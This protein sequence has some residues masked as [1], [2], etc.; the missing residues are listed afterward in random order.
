MSFKNTF[1]GIDFQVGNRAQQGQMDRFSQAV[2]QGI[3]QYNK[4]QDREL[5]REALGQKQRAAEAAAAQDY[6][7]V[8]MNELN[9]IAMGGAPTPDGQAAVKVMQQTAQDRMYT[10]IAGNVRTN[11][12]PWKN[13]G[14]GEDQST[15]IGGDTGQAPST[16]LQGINVPPVTQTQLQQGAPQGSATPFPQ[17]PSPE[18]SPYADVTQVQPALASDVTTSDYYKAP[19]SLGL[20]GVVADSQFAQKAGI[21]KLKSDLAFRREQMKSDKGREKVTGII[22]KSMDDLETLN[23]KLKAK[24]AIINNDASLLQN[25]RSK[26][27]ASWLGKQTSSVTKPEIETLRQ[28]FEVKRDSI[29][30]S[31]I[32]YFD[33][34]ATV[35]DTEEFQQ[36]ILQAFGD[37]SLAYETNE[38]ALANMRHQF[39]MKPSKGE[40]A[41]PSIDQIRAELNR[42]RGQ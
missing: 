35:V 8:A 5:Q 22:G 41:Q 25:L 23:D 19:A 2:G 31:Y 36:R 42:R 11:K 37:P 6:E 27:G 40:K 12:S 18:Q 30:P 7:Q 10:D 24:Q 3:A 4:A 21:E 20:A 33:L 9:R 15:N 28:Q 29:I 38:A 14:T 39:G 16:L 1:G 17:P 13:I 32:A 26:Y 34:P